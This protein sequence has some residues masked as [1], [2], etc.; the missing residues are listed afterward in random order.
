M[1]KWCFLSIVLL[2]IAFSGC[3]KDDSGGME[4]AQMKLEEK[5]SKLDVPEVMK[6]STN[7][8]AETAVGCVDYVKGIS[9]Y[10]SWFDIPDDAQYQGL[11]STQGEVY[12]WSYGGFSIWE[13]YNDT[14]SK[15]TWQVDIDGG[16]GR[17]KYL[18]SEEDYNGDNGRM[19]VSDYTTSD[20]DLIYSYVWYFNS[21]GDATLTWQDAAG[22]FKYEVKSNIDLSGSAKMYSIGK[23]FYNFQWNSDGSGSCEYYDTDGSVILSDTWSVSDL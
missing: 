2:I 7:S 8:Y 3:K 9:D 22:S 15:Y 6:N 21:A 20:N 23:L 1:K 16:A 13:T 5:L 14:G 17:Q 19:E 18:Y 4:V 11:K 10:F 12:T